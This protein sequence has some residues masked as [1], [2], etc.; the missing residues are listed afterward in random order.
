MFGPP[1]GSALKPSTESLSSFPALSSKLTPVGRYEAR[2][3]R[4][5]GA[6]LAVGVAVRER[7]HE[8]GFVGAGRRD[9]LHDPLGRRLDRVDARQ[10]QRDGDLLDHPPHLGLMERVLEG[11]NADR[12]QGEHQGHHHEHLDQREAARGRGRALG[13]SWRAL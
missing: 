4:L 5:G 10:P 3:H 1:A 7:P 11:R 6:Q 13:F 2:Q 9:D 12:H 8:G